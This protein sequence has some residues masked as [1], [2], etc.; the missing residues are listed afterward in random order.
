MLGADC[1]PGGCV[2]ASGGMTKASWI[3]GLAAA[4]GLNLLSISGIADAVVEWRC[5]LDLRTLVATYQNLRHVIFGF[6]PFHMPD[7]IQHYL[8]VIGSFGV[9]LNGYSMLTSGKPYS[10]GFGPKSK[11][12]IYW[13]R[14]LFYL[15]PYVFLV[16]TAFD[17]QERSRTINRLKP[18]AGDAD[19]DVVEVYDRLKGEL[20]KDRN[21][22][23]AIVIMYPVFCLAF[24]FL[25]SDVGY[26][27]F[28]LS[29]IGGVRFPSTCTA[30]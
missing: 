10:I 28:G 13:F 25:F 17:L 14:I 6:L 12:A 21:T 9:M 4:S 30:S 27:V 18:T 2:A 23:L 24:L 22:Y 19:V 29:E 7:F 5:F 3:A 15:F 26:K 20:N 8:I 11:P 1:D 16:W